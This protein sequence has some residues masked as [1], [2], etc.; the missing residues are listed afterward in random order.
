M[1]TVIKDHLS[2]LIR[3][4]S[5][6]EIGDD[7]SQGGV[8]VAPTRA[9]LKPPSLYRVVM[10]NDDFT[11]MDFVVEVL[12]RFF[13][14]DLDKATTTMLQVHTKGK[15]QCGT[16]SKD[17]AQTKASQVMRYAQQHDHPLKC[18]IEPVDVH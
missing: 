17:V 3:A 8:A 18:E 13:G 15:A 11:P 6:D 1:A 9:K 10:L 2:Y 5:K 4:S 14:M 16:F 7:H 12:Q